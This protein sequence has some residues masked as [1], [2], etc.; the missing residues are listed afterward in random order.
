[1]TQAYSVPSPENEHAIED[2]YLILSLADE[3][4]GLELS[5]VEEIRCWETATRVPNQ[6]S[7]VRGV[8]NLR[9]TIIPLL[10]LRDRLQM[11]VCE[12]TGETIVVVVLVED[13][14]GQRKVGVVVDAVSDVVG[15]TV[16][17]SASRSEYGGALDIE[18][19]HGLIAV[20]EQVIR[21]LDV[22]KLLP[23]RLADNGQ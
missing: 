4:F 14:L 9:G 20:D 15:T 3:T 12:Y 5:R 13:G 22:D 21:L 17:V 7:F 1:M 8:M 19:L 11:E 2:E 16:E 6:P 10:D 18:L 23:A